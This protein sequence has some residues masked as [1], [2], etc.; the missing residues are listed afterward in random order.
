MRTIQS[1]H[2][3]DGEL[4]VAFA[5]SEADLPAWES[6]LEKNGIA[7]EISCRIFSLVCHGTR[8]SARLGPRGN[9]G[10]RSESLNGIPRGEIRRRARLEAKVVL[11]IGVVDPLSG[12]IDQDAHVR[13]YFLR[14]WCAAYQR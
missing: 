12:E 10:R 9:P 11:Q 8:K 3:G 13:G 2:D 7:I 5:I 6:W 1:P 14:H 4:H